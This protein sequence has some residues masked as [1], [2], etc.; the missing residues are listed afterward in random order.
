MNLEGGV[1]LMDIL[2]IFERRTYDHS[3]FWLGEYSAWKGKCP[4]HEYEIDGPFITWEEAWQ[5]GEDHMML[6]PS[7]TWRTRNSSL[8]E[9]SEGNQLY[10]RI[11]PEGETKV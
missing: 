5:A 4:R 7:A 6:F 9:D 10:S 3:E 11:Q 8:G 2:F 1:I